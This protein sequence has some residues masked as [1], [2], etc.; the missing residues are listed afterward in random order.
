MTLATD[1]DKWTYTKLF[2]HIQ[3]NLGLGDFSGEPSKYHA[4]KMQQIGMIKRMMLR[5]RLKPSEVVMCAE[6]CKA[7]R[8]QPETYGGLLW[9]I[10]QARKWNQNG[11][12]DAIQ[13]DVDSAVA[14]EQQRLFSD[15]EASRWMD[16]LL[17]STGPSRTEVLNRWKK[18][19]S[20]L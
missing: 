19:R 4:W 2:D 11:T 7:H 14:A 17:R 5:R 18:E 16:M 1:V 9:Y 20:H 15:E 10:D 12:V 13:E 3:E 6:Y 8:I